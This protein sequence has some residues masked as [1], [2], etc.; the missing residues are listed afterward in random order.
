MAAYQT[1]IDRLKK[2]KIEPKL[3]ILDNECSGEY[4]EAIRKNGMKFQFVPPNDHRRNIAEKA[5]QVFKDHFIAVLCGTDV[6]FPMH[7]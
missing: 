5:I 1:L 3:H 4:K 2:V 6:S 7:L